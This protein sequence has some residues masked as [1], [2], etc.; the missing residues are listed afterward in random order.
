M[1][2]YFLKD[3]NFFNAE[4]IILTS[5]S[6]KTALSLAYLLNE[7]QSKDKKNIIGITSK[8]NFEF[9]ETVKFYD[10]VVSY[11]D[12]KSEIKKNKSLIID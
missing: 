10:Q 4:Q 3:E 6:S 8:K 5:A 12:I 7:N 9:V 11:S 1:N 2:Y